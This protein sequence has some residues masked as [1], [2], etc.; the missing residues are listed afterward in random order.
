MKE[1]LSPHE[2][3]QQ[4]KD[5]NWSPLILVRKIWGWQHV[6]S[7]RVFLLA[8]LSVKMPKVGDFVHSTKVIF[9]WAFGEVSLMM[10]E[11]AGFYFDSL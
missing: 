4:E 6:F 8:F 9:P 5:L 11:G 3:V 7:V 10:G 1:N 2:I